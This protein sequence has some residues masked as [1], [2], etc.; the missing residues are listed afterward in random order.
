[1]RQRIVLTVA[2][3]VTDNEALSALEALQTKMGMADS[4]VG[5]AREVQWEL[6]VEADGPE[7]ALR[8]VTE[9]V[10]RTNV[11]LNPNKHRSTL[12][13]VPHAWDGLDDDEVAILVSDR[14]GAESLAAIAA[15]SR[16]GVTGLRKATR[17]I[18]WRVRLAEAPSREQPGLLALMRKIGVA[19]DRGT[20]LLSNPHSQTALVAF[21]WGEEKT[22][23]PS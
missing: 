6:D 2:L 8:V 23:E 5:L 16:I 7:S 4:V 22:L 9:I 18:R 17:R 19:S 20:G 10:K 11:F 1:M 21:P 14:D 13:S 15:G 12:T 3:K